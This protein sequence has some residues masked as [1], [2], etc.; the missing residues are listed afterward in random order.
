MYFCYYVEMELIFFIYLVSCDLSITVID[1][2][3]FL[4]LWNSLFK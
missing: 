1:T 4:N 3:F 2:D